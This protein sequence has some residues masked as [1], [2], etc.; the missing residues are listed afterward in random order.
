MHASV[1]LIFLVCLLKILASPKRRRI[2]RCVL[3]SF[4]PKQ[5][6]PQTKHS[7][8]KPPCGKSRNVEWRISDEDSEHFGGPLKEKNFYIAGIYAKMLSTDAHNHIISVYL[9]LLG[10]SAEVKM[11]WRQTI[12]NRENNLP[13]SQYLSRRNVS[14][15][16]LAFFFLLGKQQPSFPSFRDEEKRDI[17]K[18][19]K[20][21]VKM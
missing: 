10:I 18:H 16:C 7:T 4:P 9:L 8:V 1:S 5:S 11:R 13:S 15:N 2:G 14:C 21:K 3:E 17:F 20:N 19:A 12:T 6:A